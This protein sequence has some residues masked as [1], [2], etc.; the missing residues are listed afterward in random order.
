VPGV[1]REVGETCG[2]EEGTTGGERKTAEPDI[3]DDL[4]WEN[5]HGQWS[6]IG[7]I[8]ASKIGKTYSKEGWWF[9]FFC[10]T[11]MNLNG[12]MIP[13]DEHFL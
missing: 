7:K 2:S 10:W 8:E 5:I 11:S 12:M 4:G 13:D 3:E 1:P 6:N 9:W